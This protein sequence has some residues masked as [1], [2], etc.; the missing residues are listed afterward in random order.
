MENFSTQHITVF[1]LGLGILLATARVLGEIAQRFRQPAVLGEMLAGVILGPTLL[2][3]ISP[4]TNAFLFP[5]SGPNAM[6]LSAITTLAVVLFLLIAGMEVDLSIVR[7]Q[8]MVAPKVSLAGILIPFVIGFAVAW[9]FPTLM[10]RNPLADPLTF[11]LF[12]ATAMSISALPVVARTLMDLGFYRSDLGMVIVSAAIVNDLVGWIV[13]AI[14]L[15]MMGGDGAHAASIPNTILLTLTFVALM[16]TAGRYLIHRLLPFLQAYTSW[17]GGVLSFA[18]VMAMLGA[19]FAE[20]IGIHA[21][22]GS[23]LVGVALGDSSHLRERTRVTIDH[24]INSVFT[25]LFFASLGLRVDFIAHFDPLLVVSVFVIATVCKLAGGVLGARWGGMSKRE[26]WAVGFALNSRGAMEIILGLLA[27]EAGLIEQPLFVALVIVAIGTSMLSG[28]MMRSVLKPKRKRWLDSLLA[29]RLF[30]PALQAGTSHEAIR[31][32]CR[33]LG[34]QPGLDVEAIQAAVWQREQTMSTGIG[35]G[36]AIPHARLEG[37][38]KPIVVAG[39]SRRG[40][41]F[42]APDEKLAQVVFL[43]LTPTADPAIQLHLIAEIARLF[44]DPEVLESVGKA[45]SYTDF[46]A[47]LRCGTGKPAAH[48]DAGSH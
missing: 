28:P 35:N 40:V 47:A 24:F 46:L 4:A 26:S 37:I 8:G 33:P 31:E 42:N 19:A 18:L 1:F 25:P 14:I 23:F 30:I 7:R 16:L 44:Q 41:D 48:A 45:R 34:S 12:F 10:G 9:L 11:A 36:V 3:A 13:F 43:I 32:L 21:I 5:Q 17:P 20:W 22:F 6:A 38:T 2:G 39:L 29:N 27:L 15:G